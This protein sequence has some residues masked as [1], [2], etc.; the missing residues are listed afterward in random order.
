MVACVRWT[1]GRWR[2]HLGGGLTR[3]RQVWSVVVVATGMRERERE[4]SGRVVVEWPS[5]GGAARDGHMDGGD[6][7]CSGGGDAAVA[8]LHRRLLHVA[9]RGG[10]NG[11]S[12]GEMVGRP[13][14]K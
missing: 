2:R 5:G 13:R 3:P 9:G 10:G 12:E 1:G 8:W 14:G 6:V 4:W 11:E 7:R